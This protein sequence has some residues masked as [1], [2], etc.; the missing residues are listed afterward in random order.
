MST[1]GKGNH[2]LTGNTRK[3]FL[4]CLEKQS[5]AVKHREYYVLRVNQFINALDG[6]DPVEL[7]DKTI[8]EVLSTID[9]RNT[10]Q[11]WQFTQF[12]EAVRIYMIDHLKLKS[13]AGFDWSYWKGSARTLA[14][15]NPSV[16]KQSRPEE[17]LRRKVQQ[18]SGPLADVRRQH[19]KLIVRFV[20]E[21]RARG[22]AYRTEQVYEQWVYRYIA[23]CNGKS[24]E[25]AGAENIA[26]FLNELVVSGNV[27]ASTQNQALNAMVF[28]YKQVLRIEFDSDTASR[29]T[30]LKQTMKYAPSRSCSVT[31]RFQRRSSTLT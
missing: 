9:R 20:T 21:I 24:P 17:L 12:I 22:Y 4:D 15:D 11:D 2:A 31:L 8:S 7:D 29:P 30:C 3:Q 13:L 16:A 25:E 5:V 10:L 27:S 6:R 26:S 28:L 19:E 23:F 1:P 18:G 14:I